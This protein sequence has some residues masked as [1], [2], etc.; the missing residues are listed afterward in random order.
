MSAAFAMMSSMLLI[1][2]RRLGA[3]QSTPDRLNEV[4]VIVIPPKKPRCVPLPPMSIGESGR[5]MRKLRP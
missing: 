3:L 1:M 2:S 5:R 4:A